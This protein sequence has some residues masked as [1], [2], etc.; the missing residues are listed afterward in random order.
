MRNYLINLRFWGKPPLLE[1]LLT[2]MDH[3]TAKLAQSADCATG[4]LLIIDGGE[5]PRMSD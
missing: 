4:A 3:G 2:T 5:A 1:S